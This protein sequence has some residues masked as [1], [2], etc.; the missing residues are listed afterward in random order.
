ML[1]A[2]TPSS[3]GASCAR[4]PLSALTH[5]AAEVAPK[6]HPPAYEDL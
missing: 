5:H 4:D 2:L 3:V 6:G 1:A